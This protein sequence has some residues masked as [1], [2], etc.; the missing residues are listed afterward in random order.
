M[1]YLICFW[2]KSKIQVNEETAN[3]LKYAISNKLIDNFTI[4][5]SLYAVGGVEKIIPKYEAFDIFPS[6][7]ESLKAMEDKTATLPAL[8]DGKNLLKPVYRYAD[9][10]ENPL[11]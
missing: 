7:F 5:D 4:G 8:T 1:S 6:E 3:K 2:D 9:L 10:N 11:I